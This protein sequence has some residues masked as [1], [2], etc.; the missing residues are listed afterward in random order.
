[1][2]CPVGREYP[3]TDPLISL[4]PRQTRPPSPQTPGRW[5]LLW[6]RNIHPQD[7]L[8]NGTEAAKKRS[9][10]GNKRTQENSVLKGL[11]PP[12]PKRQ[13]TKYSTTDIVELIG[14]YVTLKKVGEKASKDFARFIARRIPASL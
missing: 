13:S 10:K 1:M 3:P 4:N 6:V 11:C 5:T 14:S 9:K 7:P 8:E 2:E 12:Y